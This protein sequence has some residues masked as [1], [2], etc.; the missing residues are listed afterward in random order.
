MDFPGLRSE[1]K[2]RKIRPAYLFTGDQDLSKEEAVEEIRR[3]VGGGRGTVRRFEASQARASEIL[4]TQR[5]L[6]LLD[7][8][9]VIVVRQAG[10]L[11]KAETEVLLAALAAP[12][13]GDDEAPPIPPL[14]FWD[15][16]LDRRSGL[17]ATIARRGGEVEFRAPRPK[18]AQTWV[19]AEASRLGH[20][21]ASG[22][23]ELLV[24]SVGT[25]LMRLRRSLEVVSLFV[26]AGGVIDEAAVVQV[27]PAARSHAM[28]ELQDALSAR[29]GPSAV[30]LLREALEEGQE[31]HLLVGVLFAELRRLQLARDVPP[32][33]DPR[34]AAEQT[35]SPAWKV[36]RLQQ[37][38]R[39]FPAPALRK[40]AEKL[41]DLDVAL[42][43]GR[44]QTAVALE[45]WLVAL[46]TP[47]R[48]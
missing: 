47:D 16:T 20:R 35:G 42:K 43:T 29:D 18:E 46:C 37:N 24:E 45:D 7:P 10:K 26:G 22:A 40:A 15:A 9:S 19:R 28:Y 25:D 12:L 38:A 14:V 17:Y 31:P 33:T 48:G 23:D 39:R 8:V 34:Q 41:A 4:E 2:Q 6:S 3:A 21:L 44:G 1:L 36:P 13:A 11:A 32:G 5:N 27:V 30:R